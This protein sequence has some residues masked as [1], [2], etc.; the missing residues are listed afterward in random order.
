MLVL[1]IDLA[2]YLVAAER[3]RTAA[4]LAALAAA[5]LAHPEIAVAGDPLRQ[6]RRVATANGAELIS[7]A[8]GPSS[9]EIEVIVSVEVRAVAV[10][11]FAGRRVQAGARAALIEVAPARS[12]PYT[13]T[14]S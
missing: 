14:D 2:A 10:T 13:P 12:P 3:A 4:D 8:C 11:R 6:A 9:G 7:C 1:I 5:G